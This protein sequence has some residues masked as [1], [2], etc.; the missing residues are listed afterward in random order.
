LVIFY[1]QQDSKRFKQKTADTFSEVIIGIDD[2]CMNKSK[3]YC[4]GPVF[5]NR[6]Y[7]VKLVVCTAGGCTTNVYSSGYETGNFMSVMFLRLSK[8]KGQ[9]CHIYSWWL[10]N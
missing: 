6:Q 10:H 7:K 3:E 4:N 2:E 9:A 1:F 5:D 8:V